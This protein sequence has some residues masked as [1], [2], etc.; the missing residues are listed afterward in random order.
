MGKK[1]YISVTAGRDD[2]EVKAVLKEFKN[3]G[4]S[5]GQEYTPVIGIQV[6]EKTLNGI[7]PNNFRLPKFHEIPSL[8]KLA[9]GKAMPVIHYN[10]KNLDT[11]P[12][13]VAKA[14]GEVYSLGYCKT[15][16]INGTWPGIE[17]VEKIKE[18]FDEISIIL[19]VSYK[20]MDEYSIAQI[21]KKVTD[22]RDCLDYILIDPSRGRGDMFDIKSSTFLFSEI[23]SKRPD[24]GI[25]FAG[26][27]SGDNVE[28]VLNEVIEEI[29]T[30]DFGI[31]AEGKLR[32]KVCD[33]H[34]GQDVLNVKKL[35]KYLKAVKK[36]LS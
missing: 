14:I 25:V 12:E 28:S 27:L 6:S 34:W 32:D 35:R 7:K 9:D 13:Q 23:K 5:M 4:Y 24:Y 16:Q 10:T 8:M 30:K 18:C 2:K 31:C 17:Q 21:P 20:G 11:L 22:Y 36:V 29:R 15:V 33:E 3:A 1:N 26:G 19:Q